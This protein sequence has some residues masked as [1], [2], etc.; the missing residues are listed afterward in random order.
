LDL[1]ISGHSRGFSLGE[2]KLLDTP[3]EEP[4]GCGARTVWECPFWKSVDEDLKRSYDIALRDLRIGSDDPQIFEQHNVYLLRS[5]IRVS[6]K[7]L[8]V[9]SSKNRDR[10]LKLMASK[11]FDVQ[12]IH[13]VRSPHGVVY[14]N[15][16]LGRDWLEHARNYA[17]ELQR[18]NEALSGKKHTSICYEELAK[19]PGFEVSR[20]MKW[21]GYDFEPSQLQWSSNPGHNVG[22]NPMRFGKS[23]HIRLDT[24]WKTGLSLWQRFSVSWITFPS[25]NGLGRFYL[26]IR[27]FWN[28]DT[29]AIKEIVSTKLEKRRAQKDKE[30]SK[31]VSGLSSWRVFEKAKLGFRKSRSFGL[32]YYWRT[33]GS[34]YWEK[35]FKKQF[36]EKRIASAE[37]GNLGELRS[38]L[39][40]NFSKRSSVFVLGAGAAYNLLALKARGFNV[41]G[42]EDRSEFIER[43]KA[44]RPNVSVREGAL[45]SLKEADASQ[46]GVL[47]MDV[48]EERALEPAPIL[49][50]ANRILANDGVCIVSF[51]YCNP[52]RQCKSMLGLF[53]F[54]KADERYSLFRR[55][56]TEKAAKRLLAD[57]GFSVE[58]SYPYDAVNGL[59][60]DVPWFERFY[61]DDSYRKKISAF[62]QGTPWIRKIVADRSL[63]VCSKRL[64][65]NVSVPVEGKSTEA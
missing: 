41:S 49:S 16:K 6:G 42:V 65:K 32:D 22:G 13:L 11:A 53:L 20:I 31:S 63:F 46:G 26:P 51:A 60:E 39:V 23:S 52:L 59:V 7:D 57:A 61:K 58:S 56:Y 10:L 12:P 17:L 21:L 38:H 40:D 55:A 14:S 37:K 24:S 1:L 45:D 8:I 27:E 50:E 29:A 18:T 35:Y 47:I 36:R 9:D 48:F 30:Y 44:I 28:F 64:A 19:H 43:L 34:E 25:R 15:V 5:V 3:R 54:G 33:P 62:A 2:I 4:C